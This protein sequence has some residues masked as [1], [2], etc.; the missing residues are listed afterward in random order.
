M[1]NNSDWG[2]NITANSSLNCSFV[3]LCI[4]LVSNKAQT[5]NRLGKWCR[6]SERNEINYTLFF[7][8][9]PIEVK[10]CTCSYVNMLVVQFNDY[11]LKCRERK[12]NDFD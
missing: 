6:F 9:N 4:S 2:R 3:G 10:L 5:K 7:Y 11:I 8:S 12:K 1:F